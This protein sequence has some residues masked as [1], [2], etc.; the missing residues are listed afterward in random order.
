VTPFDFRTYLDLA[1]WLGRRADSG[2][3]LPTHEA[4]LRTVIRRAYYAAFHVASA[5]VDAKVQEGVLQWPRTRGSM[6]DKVW[7]AMKGHPDAQIV[8]LAV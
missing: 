4:A 7:E 5:F 1:D 8:A 3:S 2:A 6:H